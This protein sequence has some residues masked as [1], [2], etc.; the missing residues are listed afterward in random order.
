MYIYTTSDKHISYNIHIDTSF[1]MKPGYMCL[2]PDSINRGEH[3]YWH[4][5]YGVTNRYTHTHDTKCQILCDTPPIATFT[6]HNT[7]PQI[8]TNQ[9][10]TTSIPDLRKRR[11][12]ITEAL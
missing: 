2:V 11:A 6:I 3:Q 7:L 10:Y 12:R 5:I 4:T 9:I 8:A 1:R